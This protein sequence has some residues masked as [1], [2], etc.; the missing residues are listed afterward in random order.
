MAETILIVEDEVIIAEDIRK[1]LQKLGY[2]VPSIASSGEE[3]VKKVEETNP[4]LVL[5]DIV[6][7]GKMDG[8][9]AAD[10]IRSRFNIPVVYLTAYADDETLERAKI[11]EPFGYIIKPFS[12]RELHVTIEMA[13]MKYRMEKK[14]KESKEWFN[15]TLKS[16]SDAVIATDAKGCVTFMNHVAQYLTGWMLDEA[17]EKPL[18]KVFDIITE[19]KD[20]SSITKVIHEGVVVDPANQTVL[21]AR[22]G[23]KIPIEE[24]GDPIRDDKGKLIGFVVVFRD[25]TEQRQA[26]V[27]IRKLKEFYESVLEGIAPGVWVTDKN[28]VIR[29][30][31]KG[32]QAIT[33]LSL[34]Q[35][36]GAQILKD[37]SEF[38]KPYYLKAKETL[39]PFYFGAV[40]LITDDGHQNCQ[41]GWLIPRI[42]DG[43]FDG[44][45]CTIESI[46]EHEQVDQE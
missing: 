41:S 24:T 18:E 9:E 46:P 16:I 13:L 31:N 5:M 33:G 19:G 8:I 42:K 36:V 3:A 11:T 43:S 1:N 39:Q 27:E 25:I 12:E 35:I 30:A 37:F 7:K 26:E 34:Q 40:P 10:K 28:D 15:S 23:K 29:Y 2:L 44:M 4:D 20:E 6:L 21:I 32:M 14:L 22:D 45:I 17:I 38:I